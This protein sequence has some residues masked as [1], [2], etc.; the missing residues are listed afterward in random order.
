[1]V[2]TVSGKTR[3]YRNPKGQVFPTRLD[4]TTF[5]TCSP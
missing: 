2:D 1:V 3:T 5:A 4:T